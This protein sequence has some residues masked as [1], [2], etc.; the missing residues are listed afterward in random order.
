ML[1]RRITLS[2]LSCFFIFASG[3][4]EDNP[5]AHEMLSPYYRLIYLT[6][7]G[8]DSAIVVDSSV[9]YAGKLAE[10]S[11]LKML[12]TNFIHNQFVQNFTSKDYT[13][14]NVK[15]RINRAILQR[16]ATGNNKPLAGLT[17]PFL[18][19]MLVRE[20]IN[21]EKE[22]TR[23]VNSF[24]TDYFARRDIYEN[25]SGRYGL[26]IYS[27]IA[28]KQVDADRLLQHIYDKLKESQIKIDPVIR[29]LQERRAWHRYLFAYANILYGNKSLKAGKTE[30]AGTYFKLAFDYSPDLI[31]RNVLSGF[32]YDMTLIFDKERH[33]FRGEYI[34]HL[35]KQN[36]RNEL[37]A[38]LLS[39]AL[40]DPDYKKKLKS[41]YE[42]H[43]AGD[44]SFDA[45][46][47]RNVNA[48]LDNAK[49]FTLQQ[50]DGPSFSIKANKGKWMLLDFW[51]T[52]CAP[53]RREHP[54]LEKFSKSIR[55][56]KDFVLLTVA[57]RDTEKKVSDYMRRNKYSFPVAMADNQIETLYGIDGYPSKILITP[58]GKYMRI[59][60]G[61]D[62]I[63]FIKNY[64]SL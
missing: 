19:W 20:N 7:S 29:P 10:N 52:W 34:D 14:S 60:F 63:N 47:L 59:P 42:A 22:V 26:L 21:D 1:L 58:Q 46:W 33:S 53:C 9:Y 28:G 51:G 25:K 24:I 30:E 48:G 45:Y 4:Q 55:K 38:V 13:A 64:A 35:G 50:M 2:I 5:A 31:D 40:I 27:L 61:V 23:L 32:Y 36:N 54:D 44:E 8:T 11:G 16:M 15:A 39:T 6:E 41:H 18:S 56:R 57:C 49:E 12:V 43:F 17:Q 3:A 62:W 37:L